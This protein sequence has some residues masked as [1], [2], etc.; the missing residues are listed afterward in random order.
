MCGIVGYIGHRQA[1]TVVLK[2]L[3]RLEYRGYDSAGIALINE[4][5]DLNIYKKAG[6]VVE[7]EKY[8]TDKDK[9][10]TIG[11]GHTRWATHGEPSDRNSHPHIS[12][13]GRLSIIHNGIIE[14]YSVLKEEL[15]TRGHEFKSDTDTEVLIHLIEE[16]YKL[17]NVDLLEA[18]RLALQE[19]TGAYAIVIV[20]Q[21]N[22]DQLIAAR[23][24]SPMVIGVGEG[25]YFIA[26]DASPII[27][28]TKNVIY[29]NDNE[30]ALVTREELLVKRLDNVV[31]TP[32]IQELE[33]KLDMLE[34]GGYEHFMLKEIYEQS[35][36]IRDCMRGRIYPNEG[37]VQLGGI[38]EYADKLKNI[39]RI[40]IVACGTSWHA[41]LVGEYLIEE[42]ARI[43][44]EVEY[45][46]EFRY[47]NPIITEKDV[48]IAI[49]QSGETA[50][51][52]AAIEMAK[53]KGATIFG[54]CNVVGSS[55]PRLTHAGVYTH[56]GPEIGVASTKAFTAQVTVLTLMAFYMAQQKGTLTQAKLVELLTELDCIPDK[57]A[58]AL[59]SNALIEEIAA[60]FKDSRNCLFLGRGSG[61]PVALEGALK[62]KEISYIHA[63]G[64]P[65]A[66]MKHGPIALIDE[67]MP[68]VV[69]ATKNSSYEKVISNIQEVK[70]RKGIVLA[71]VT[72]G[73]TE[74]RKMADYCIEIPDSSE[75]F[76]PLL[77]TIPL[78]LLSYHIALMRGCNVDQPR[79]LAKSVT[80]E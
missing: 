64:Y 16:I 49:S 21:D 34:K 42:Y 11:M 39:D 63:E 69:I 31:Q 46:S 36:S 78:Q 28:Y 40:I 54:V 9:S 53:E 55:I 3:K 17:E 57:V 51:T 10:G 74:V 62:L 25:E 20:D 30:I 18:V 79:N 12:N 4:A 26:S 76:L 72:E 68:V 70:A 77:A 45:A 6:K 58:K 2:G 75:A 32:V 38:K 7:L 35:R 80:V 15:L 8:S 23:K 22:P 73:D 14:N 67:E 59:E 47:R 43:P 33:M 24:G 27:E 56:A 5:G 13:N 44:V 65:A 29:M 1:W 19:V 61:F 41:G 37:L 66:E 60:K 50:D 71:I 52:M 48:V